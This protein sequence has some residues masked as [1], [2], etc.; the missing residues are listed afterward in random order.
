[1]LHLGEDARDGGHGVDILFPRVRGLSLP[2]FVVG[3]GWLVRIL[4]GVQLGSVDDSL[5]SRSV[6][7]LVGGVFGLLFIFGGFVLLHVGVTG[8]WDIFLVLDFDGVVVCFEIVRLSL[9]VV[10]FLLFPQKLYDGAI[11]F[12][13]I[14]IIAVQHRVSNFIKF[15]H[16]P[17]EYLMCFGDDSLHFLG[18]LGIIQC[19]NIIINLIFDIHELQFHIGAALFLFLSGL[20]GLWRTRFTLGSIWILSDGGVIGLLSGEV[21]A[22]VF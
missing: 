15:I 10:Y 5:L 4:E 1:L 21:D 8:F 18:F 6:G 9:S 20:F 16:F 22:P 3:E 12:N 14:L 17:F 13:K 19:S 2:E 11:V 7:L